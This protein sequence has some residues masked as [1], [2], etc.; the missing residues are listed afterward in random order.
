MPKLTQALQAQTISKKGA[1]SIEDWLN[2]W[3]ELIGKKNMKQLFE[4]ARVQIAPVFG[5]KKAFKSDQALETFKPW[6]A[7]LDSQEV[8][9]FA[10]RYIYPKLTALIKRLEVD[11]SD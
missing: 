8:I 4:V 9:V 1:T 3:C 6:V 2:P 11:P 10:N 7:I 5:D